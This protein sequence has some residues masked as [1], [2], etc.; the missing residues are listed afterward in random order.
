MQRLILIIILSYLG[1]RLFK[2][3]FGSREDRRGSI[4]ED[5]SPGGSKEMIKDPQCNT[6]IPKDEAVRQ[7]IKGQDYYFCSKECA[8]RFKEMKSA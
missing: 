6:Y 8:Q 1:Y 2:N 3:L 4:P 5:L 7:Q